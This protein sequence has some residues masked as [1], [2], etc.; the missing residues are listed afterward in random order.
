MT[1]TINLLD[2]PINKGGFAAAA[3]LAVATTGCAASS[4]ETVPFQLCFQLNHL[5]RWTREHTLQSKPGEQD[6]VSKKHSSE[7]IP[8]NK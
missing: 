4:Q 8:K 6:H 5:M 2:E 3:A 7:R 1:E